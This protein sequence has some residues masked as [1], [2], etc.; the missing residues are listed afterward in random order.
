MES[1]LDQSHHEPCQLF[2]L[3]K[4]FL[5][6][7]GQSQAGEMYHRRRLDIVSVDGR[8]TYGQLLLSAHIYL[9]YTYIFCLMNMYISTHI[10]THRDDVEN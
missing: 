7:F 1:L 6:G 4:E 5:V 3:S 9:K 8:C 2:S 10:H